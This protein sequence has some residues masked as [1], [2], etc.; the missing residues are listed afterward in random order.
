MMKLLGHDLL[1]A[2]TPTTTP[3]YANPYTPPYTYPE[4]YS[5]EP[6]RETGIYPLRRP[7]TS[8]Q[9]PFS[10]HHF[11][12]PP[13]PGPKYVQG[14]IGNIIPATRAPWP[15]P[16]IISDR[17]IIKILV[18]KNMY[19]ALAKRGLPTMTLRRR[20]LDENTQREIESE[21][22]RQTMADMVLVQNQQYQ[23]IV[24]NSTKRG[25]ATALSTWQQEA[26]KYN[27]VDVA[28]LRN[29]MSRI[30]PIQSWLSKG[31]AVWPVELKG[32]Q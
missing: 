19:A 28:E 7:P 3:P 2:L 8:P 6:Y 26:I 12:T 24:T 17:A 5:P 23:S 13:M 11:V 20:L 16:K 14:P 31:K 9:L 10:T 1:G 18:S 32:G 27:L 4:V 15:L 29:L 22:F 30:V 25:S 21:V